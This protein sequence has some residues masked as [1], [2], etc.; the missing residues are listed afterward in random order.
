MAEEQIIGLILSAGQQTRFDSYL[1]KSLMKY[2]LDNTVLDINIKTMSKFCDQIY[3]VTNKENDNLL[4]NTIVNKYNNVTQISINSGLGDGHAVLESLKSIKFKNN[5]KMFLVWGDSI[6]DDERLFVATQNAYNNMFTLP[7]R[8]EKNPYVQFVVDYGIV[9]K[10]KFKKYN[11]NIEDGYHDYSLFLFK[12]TL[13]LNVL[14]L[15][16]KKYW[17]EEEKKYIY[18]NNELVFLDV[19]NE[20]QDKLFPYTVIIDT[21]GST[22]MNSYNTIDEYKKIIKRGIED[23]TNIK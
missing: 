18:R 15:H 20:Y 13:M 3:V 7:L 23:D 22:S 8:Y 14:T 19:I 21:V 11:D 2:N 16:H 4:Y 17:K 12:P 9:R 5:D 1:P 10:V 6:Q